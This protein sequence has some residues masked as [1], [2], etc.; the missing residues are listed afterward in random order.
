MASPTAEKGHAAGLGS[1]DGMPYDPSE[2]THEL[3]WPLNVGVY[4]RMRRQDAKVKSIYNAVTLPLR[5][6]DFRLDPNGADP[7][8]VDMIAEDLGVPILEAD[9]VPKRRGRQRLDFK[10][11]VRL[12]CL[13]L[14]YG[15]MPFEKTGVIQDGLWRLRTLNERLPATLAKINTDRAG[16]LLSIQQYPSAFREAASGGVGVEL[17]GDSIVMYSHEREGGLWQGNSILRTAYKHWLIKDRLIRVD[18]MKHERNGLG[19]P[20]IEAPPGASDKTIEQLNAIASRWR[21]SETSG[22]G[23]PAGAK[24]HLEGVT[25]SLPDTLGSIRYHDEQ[26]GEEMLAQ[27]LDLGTTETGSR[28]LGAAFIDF[29][30]LSL[31]AIADDLA[32]TL[33]EQLIELWVDWNWGEDVPAP[34]LVPA[35]VGTDHS[36]TAEAIGSLVQTGVLIAD[37]GLESWLRDHYRM[38]KREGPRP[39]PA[40]PAPPAPAATPPVPPVTAERRRLPFLAAAPGNTDEA[41]PDWPGGAFLSALT[42]WG[43]G[44]VQAALDDVVASVDPTKLARDTLAVHAANVNPEM[45]DVIARLRDL[46]DAA[47]ARFQDELVRMWGEAYI[48]GDRV[49]SEL[50]AAVG[51]TVR[52]RPWDAAVAWDT[53]RPGYQDAAA[54]IAGRDGGR[55]LARLLDEAGVTIKDV[56]ETTLNRIADVL[57]AALDEGAGVEATARRLREVIASPVRAEMIA[58]TEMARAMTVA[59]LDSYDEHGITARE[60]LLSTGACPLCV[61]N[62]AAGVVA[63]ASSFPNGDPPVHPRCVCAIA[64]VINTD[65]PVED[66][67][68]PAPTTE[69]A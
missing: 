63:L 32:D 5:R 65:Y 27:F 23:L 42:T 37:D 54:Q 6:N 62:E 10:E 20:W 17:A 13:S 28:A 22:A 66:R 9:P 44:L 24:L 21:V 57:T 43:V 48:A 8:M 14:I 51:L 34:R 41:N 53:W 67:G 39:A 15:H 40:K 25:G 2:W 46:V 61:E 69:E 64:P 59:T 11:H 26:I 3:A 58:Q 55:G 36:I 50:L 29:F 33:N 30:V 60:W 19:V 38:P 4:D 31:Q 56:T 45:D 49:A 35:D 47:G 52:E 18:A 16:N 68:T 1:T 7:A 12:A